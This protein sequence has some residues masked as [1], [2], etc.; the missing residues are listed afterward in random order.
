[1]KKKLLTAV[2]VLASLCG[3]AQTKGTNALGFGINSQTS[4]SEVRSETGATEIN[5]SNSNNFTLSYGLFIKD[6]TKLGLDVSYGNQDYEYIANVSGSKGKSYGA[7]INYQQYYP[8]VKKLY[9]FAGGS[10]GYGYTKTDYQDPNY[11]DRRSDRYSVGVDGGLT[12]FFSKRFAIES[13][14]LSAS[15]FYTVDKQKANNPGGQTSYE[16][17]YTNFNLSSSGAFNNLGFK[18]YLLF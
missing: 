4:K 10:V 17:R 14:L 1:M 11:E 18:I 9:A 3:Y 16:N 12:W 5:K 2:A 7:G 15:A 8:L 6:N 13:S